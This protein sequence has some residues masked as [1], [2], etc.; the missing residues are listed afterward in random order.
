MVYGPIFEGYVPFSYRERCNDRSC[1]E[2]ALSLFAAEEKY[3]INRSPIYMCTFKH[4]RKKYHLPQAG[5]EP[6]S[7]DL[8]ADG[9]PQY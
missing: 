2:M 9:L 5:G 7:L 1:P 4:T 3:S 8:K 6:G